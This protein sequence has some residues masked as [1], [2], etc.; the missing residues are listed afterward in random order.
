MIFVGAQSKRAAALTILATQVETYGS[1]TREICKFDR[2]EPN[3][4]RPLLNQGRQGMVDVLIS[5][6]DRLA[7]Y[8]CLIY[9]IYSE[10]TPAKV[11]RTV[12]LILQDSL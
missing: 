6:S 10:Y 5:A 3:R 1:I 2:L 12:Y 4:R 9:T 8:V 7:L 11:T